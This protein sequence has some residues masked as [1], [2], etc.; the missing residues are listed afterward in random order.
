M[1]KVAVGKESVW[2]V[3]ELGD[4]YVRLGVS[5][6]EPEGYEWCY[7]YS[8]VNAVTIGNMDQLVVTMKYS[9]PSVGKLTGLMAMRT[10]CS[11]DNPKGADWEYGIC[12][13]WISI[14]LID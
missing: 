14:G 7:V 12:G 2:A 5:I 6:T 3:D 13:P 9:D 11:K 10:H 8:D 4:L 1:V